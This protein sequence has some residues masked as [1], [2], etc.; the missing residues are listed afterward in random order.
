MKPALCLAGDFGGLAGCRVEGKRRVVQEGGR[1]ELLAESDLRIACQPPVALPYRVSMR[2]RLPGKRGPSAK[3]LLTA[4]A[5]PKGGYQVELLPWGD[6]IDVRASANGTKLW[7]RSTYRFGEGHGNESVRYRLRLDPKE[8]AAKL[9]RMED[10][11][12][13][14]AK[15]WEEWG[16]GT[17][18]EVFASRE[19]RGLGEVIRANEAEPTA[20]ERSTQVAMDVSANAVRMWVDGR[21]VGEVREPPLPSSELAMELSAGAALENFEAT[22]WPQGLEEFVPLDL[23]GYCNRV[24]PRGAARPAGLVRVDGVPLLLAGGPAGKDEIDVGRS[25]PLETGFGRGFLGSEFEAASGLTRHPS[26]IVL[27]VPKGWFHELCLLAYADREPDTEPV[28]SF[29]FFRGERTGT[30][31][32]YACTVPYSDGPGT[33]RSAA[34]KLRGPGGKDFFLHLVRVPLEPMLMQHWLEKDFVRNLQI[35]VTRG[36]RF[37]RGY[38]DPGEYHVV[39]GGRKSCVRILGMT[40]R[41]S[42][43]EMLVTPDEVGGLTVEP[44]RPHLNIQVRNRLAEPRRASLEIDTEDP[45]ATKKQ[46]SDGLEIP[47][48]AVV[49]KRYPLP[50][51]KYGLHRVRVALSGDGVN[52]RKETTLG[53]LPPDTRRAS[54]NDSFFGLWTWGGGADGYAYPIRPEET[55]RLV[56]KLGGR[57]ALSV[58]SPAMGRHYG[59]TRSWSF[60]PSINFDQVPRDQWEVELRRRMLEELRAQRKEFPAQEIY[61]LFGEANLGLKQTFA[62]PGRYYGEPDYVLNEKEQA[63]FDRLFERAVVT[64]K[65][66]KAIKQEHPEFKNVKAT[67]GNTSPSFHIAFLKRGLPRE[68]IDAFGI[69]IPYFERMPERQPRAVEASQLLYLHDFRKE[70][71]CA[72]IPV[73]GTEDMYYPGCPGSLSQ[74][75]QADYYVRCHLLKM[76]LGVAREVSVGMVFATAGPYGK[77]H[78]GSTGLFEVAPEGGGDGNPRQSAVAYATMT[79]ILDG[80]KYLRYFPTGSL[81]TFCLALARQRG[82]G[83]VLALWTLEGK[84]EVSISLAVDAAVQVTDAMGNSRAVSSADKVLK[85]EATSSPVWVE[86]LKAAQITGVAAGEAVYDAR[87]AERHTLLEDFDAPWRAAEAR[88][89]SYAENNFDLPRFPAAMASSPAPGFDGGK[90]LQIVLPKP[91]KE[92]KLAPWYAAFVP[93]KPIAIPG[94]PTQLG[95]YVKGNSG[96]GRVIPQVTDAKGELWTFVGPKDEWNSDDVFSQSSVN[97]DGWKYIQIDLP[98]NLPNGWPGPAMAF[99]K[100][101]KG[102]RTVDYPLRLTKLI[103]EQRTHVYYVNEILPVPDCSLVLDKIVCEYGDPYQQLHL[104]KGW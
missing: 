4:S 83:D 94:R 45:Y 27:Q 91:E 29:R 73:Y 24:A 46:V 20:A 26:R 79:R 60:L 77:T 62:L 78:Y 104:T 31:V 34:I 6:W 57:W 67:F 16:L 7:A 61:L 42:P 63:K 90:A 72:D 54:W 88:D 44:G 86:G 74:R 71:G 11:L 103:V 66:L 89:V 95:L 2:V 21:L 28:V 13:G 82:A 85:V 55:L 38:P 40:F 33:G 51:E 22:P 19:I 87:P 59:I 65:V 8:L 56:W 12:K 5:G 39:A 64:G 100:N 1:S 97:F 81:S 43:L 98:G 10:G 80:P 101:E 102:D 68:C 75:Q 58:E 35:E 9:A 93:P 18:G 32:D 37:T 50:L 14:I 52:L 84:R 3:V 49:I 41:Q 48:R 30:V 15:E 36:L 17:R 69:D 99:W 53:H 76:A 70:S 23:S 96:W 25:A 92:R 47:P